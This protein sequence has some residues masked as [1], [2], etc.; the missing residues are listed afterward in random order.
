MVGSLAGLEADR[1]L[2][3]EVG[4]L[5]EQV[6]AEEGRRNLAEVGS[7]VAAVVGILAGLVAAVVDSLAEQVELRTEELVAGRNLAELVVHHIVEQEAD[8][9]LVLEGI[10]GLLAVHIR[11]DTEV[12]A[13]RSLAV[14]VA[15]LADQLGPSLAELHHTLAATVVDTCPLELVEPLAE[16][17][18][19]QTYP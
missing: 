7:L 18:K 3:A 12:V 19:R 6:A 4:T 16:H 1:S 15:S 13:C 5:A 2:A 17:H 9:S 10:V 11:E 14:V 8:R